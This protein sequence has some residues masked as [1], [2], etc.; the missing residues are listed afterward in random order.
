MINCIALE[1]CNMDCCLAK[2]LTVNVSHSLRVLMLPLCHKS[3][4]YY[5]KAQCCSFYVQSTPLAFFEHNSGPFPRAN[6]FE[7]NTVITI[8]KS[9]RTEWGA[10]EPAPCRTSKSLILKHSGQSLVPPTRLSLLAY[11]EEGKIHGSRSGAHGAEGDS[12]LTRP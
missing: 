5:F 6:V 9:G 1:K 12:R 11:L 3:H 10:G 8:T 4:E 2:Q 7:K